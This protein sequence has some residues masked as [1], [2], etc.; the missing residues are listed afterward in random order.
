[1]TVDGSLLQQVRC[2][3]NKTVC[4]RPHELVRYVETVATVIKTLR[5][6]R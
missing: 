2:A 5:V 3:E 6:K 1:L 4:T